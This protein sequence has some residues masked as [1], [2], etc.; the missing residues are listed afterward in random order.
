MA[1]T[2]SN[3][4]ATRQSLIE[5]AA[6]KFAEKGFR[7]VSIRD[8]AGAAEVNPALIAYH[9][10]GKEGIFEEVIR[11][12]AADH[13]AQRMHDL[14]RA[15][16]KGAEIGLEG[17]LR[18]YLEPL[19]N[20]K[21]WSS[22]RANFARLHASLINE[23]SE[24]AEEIAARAFNTVNLAFIDEIC[25]VLPHLPREVVIWRFY[26]MIGSL[27]F[28]DTRPT[29][30]GLLVVSGGKCDSSDGGEVYRQMI[31]VLIAAFSAPAPEAKAAG[32]EQTA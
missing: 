3:S 30:P 7:A 6:D 23:R 12:S 22:N 21:K 17:L 9:F 19:L 10:G 31:P 18:I 14:T 11:A 29:P 27:L 13:V 20:K 24:V 32:Q 28:F 26:A 16:A 25:A 4:A 5:A 2:N 1:R 8:I 15:R